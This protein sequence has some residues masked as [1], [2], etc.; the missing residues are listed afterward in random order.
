MKIDTGIEKRGNSFRFTVYC[1]YDLA[2]KQIRKTET[3][4][5]AEGLTERQAIKAAKEEYIHF[6]NRCNGQQEFNENMRFKDLVDQYF[7]IYA[8]NKLKPVTLYNYKHMI[9]L[10]LI[11]YFGN[12]KLKDI[13]TAMLSSFFCSMIK[14]DGQPLASRSVERIFNVMQSLMRFAESQHFIKETP[15]KGVM[16]PKSD[17][18]IDEKRK[19][20]TE[21]ELPRFLKML[22]PEESENVL[23][24]IIMI[25]LYSGMRSGECLGLSWSDIDFENNIIRITHSLSEIGGNHFLTTPKTK[26]SIRFIHMSEPL[27]RLFLLQKTYQMQLQS[28]S[29]NFMHP[30]MVFTTYDGQYKGRTYLNSQFRRLLEGTEFE[31]MTLHCLRHTNATL[32]LNSGVDLKIVSEHLGH[33]GVNITGNVYAAVL[34]SSKQKTAEIIE[35]K[36]AK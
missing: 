26:T 5:P 2:G 24:R 17:S 1:G 31:F 20:L 32:L 36:L 10:R 23:D 34:K 3:F 7:K 27:K 22:H 30:E 6:K 16:L 18:T 19:Y 14:S 12:K 13:N 29:V 25:L 21:D 11:P 33:S 28:M 15:C 9:D 35:L 8:P 4:K